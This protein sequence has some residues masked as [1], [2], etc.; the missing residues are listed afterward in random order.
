MTLKELKKFIKSIPK[1]YDDCDIKMYLEEE[2]G[3]EMDLDNLVVVQKHKLDPAYNYPHCL[4]DKEKGE[5]VFTDEKELLFIRDFEVETYKKAK[6]N[7]FNRYGYVESFKAE[8]KD[9]T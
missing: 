5:F 6:E 3:Y 7:D 1:E 8:T 2:L 4:Y 9:A